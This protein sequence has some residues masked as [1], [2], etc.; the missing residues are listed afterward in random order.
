MPNLLTLTPAAYISDTMPKT[1]NVP[2]L[3][4]RY[5]ER[6][7]KDTGE[8]FT[9][10]MAAAELSIPVKTLHQWI[11]GRRTPRGLTLEML[12]QKIATPHADETKAEA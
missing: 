1:V 2:N 6:R 3:L 8:P 7:K 12:K 4:R 10:E 11:Q 5:I 9:Q